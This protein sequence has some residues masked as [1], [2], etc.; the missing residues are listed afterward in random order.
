V[1]ISGDTIVVGAEQEDSSATG[2]NGENNNNALQAGAAYVFVRDGTSWSQQA[3]LKASN[4]QAGDQFGWS[5]SISEDTIVVGAPYE[6]SKF[7]TDQNNHDAPGAG[8]AYVFVRNGNSWRQ[9]DYLKASNP[10]SGDLF[11]CSVSISGNTIVVGAEREDSM[12][13]GV[14]HWDTGNSATDS[15]A[16]YVFVRNGITWTQQAYIK[17]S[18]TIVRLYFG[19][20]LCIS[21][22]TFVV[23]AQEYENSGAAYVFVRNDTTWSQQA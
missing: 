9:Q 13:T 1:S 15:G 12:A 20:P 18:D 19:N 16:A 2:V 6:D 4:T 22:D 14:N 11:G 3:Y 7:R 8:A 17:P 21:G 5:V 23:G 10:D